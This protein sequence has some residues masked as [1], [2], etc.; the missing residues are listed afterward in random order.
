MGGLSLT[1]ILAAQACGKEDEEK[2]EEKIFPEKDVRD[3][4]G[5]VISIKDIIDRGV[6]LCRIVFDILTG[7]GKEDIVS[8]IYRLNEK[9]NKDDNK[10]VCKL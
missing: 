9:Y 8:I 2:K 1:V 5:A 10:T 6:F 3:T 7:D 4:I